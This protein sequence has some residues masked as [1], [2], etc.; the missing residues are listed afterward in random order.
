MCKGYILTIIVMQ[1]KAVCN[2]VCVIFKLAY[3]FQK[4]SPH[5]F[6]IAES[7]QKN[8]INKVF[9]LKLAK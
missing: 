9:G 1:N 3:W 4:L 6:K 2:S 7:G 8:G 5:S